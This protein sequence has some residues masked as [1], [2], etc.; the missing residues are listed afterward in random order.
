MRKKLIAIFSYSLEGGGAERVVATLANG[1]YKS[2]YLVD[3]VLIKRT[4]V[5]LNELVPGIRVI[6]LALSRTVFS[7][8]SLIRYLRQVRP[9]AML[10][11]QVHIN[12]IA[13]IA[14]M[15]AK[16]PPFRLLVREACTQSVITKNQ[17]GLMTWLTLKLLRV[18]YPFADCIIS[19]SQGVMDDLIQGFRMPQSLGVVIPNPL[20]IASI[21]KQAKVLPKHPW[22][23]SSGIPVV[24]GIGRLSIQK[25]FKTLIHAF[26]QVC[27]NRQAK[28]VILGEGEKRSELQK[29][30]EDLNLS[31]QVDLVGF[32]NNPF[33]Y[34][35][36]SAVYVLSSPSEG[37]PNTL[38]EAM[39][40]GIPVVST[41]CPSGP[42]EILEGGRWGR[43]VAVGDVDAMVEAIN[44]ALNGKVAIAPFSVLEEQYGIDNI[45]KRYLGALTHSASKTSLCNEVS[46]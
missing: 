30:V 23:D 29:L 41:D 17:E 7:L 12:I 38:L 5:Y 44:A 11:T 37:L 8:L 13:I 26:A 6:D 33:A 15:V 28:L 22:F 40:V 45:V 16:V 9:V 32:V 27:R 42:R 14:R 34:L 35:N 18:F 3:V 1:F 43:L 19:P 24:I 36:R 46:L 20:P 25:D 10:A 21:Q 4:G 2:G 31:N 39:A